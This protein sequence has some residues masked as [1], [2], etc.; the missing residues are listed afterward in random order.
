MQFSI[1]DNVIGPYFHCLFYDILWIF[2]NVF[3]KLRFIF[4][5][6]CILKK[7]TPNYFWT[8]SM[9]R[10]G[11][12]GHYQNRAK[13]EAQRASRVA[14]FLHK[15]SRYSGTTHRGITWYPKK[16]I[17][18]RPGFV[19]RPN[20]LK[21]GIKIGL[22]K[23]IWVSKWKNIFLAHFGAFLAKKLNLNWPVF[24]LN[25]SGGT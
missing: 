11:V 7:K 24:F 25:G 18:R 3:Q 8:R 12:F 20:E 6:F 9:P 1:S 2:W 4:K 5:I 10:Y 17:P 16:V 13:R 19:W 23:V 22:Y 15:F 21:F 14:R